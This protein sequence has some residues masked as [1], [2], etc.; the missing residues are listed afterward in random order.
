MGKALLDVANRVQ[1]DAFDALLRQLLSKR[2]S[3]HDV[4]HDTQGLVEVEQRLRHA[5]G[6]ADDVTVESIHRSLAIDRE[7]YQAFAAAL[8]TGSGKDFERSETL[9]NILREPDA[10]LLDLRLFYLTKE[11]APRKS[12]ANKPVSERHPWLADFAAGEQQRLRHALGQL[13]D[14]ER[15]SATLSVLRIG[16]S[17]V[18][19]FERA[20]RQ[21]GAYDFDDLIIRT[22]ELLGERP[23]AAWVLYKLDGGIEHLLVDEAQ[24]TSPAQWEIVRALTDEFF[25]GEG[26]H[27]ARRRTVF[28]VGDRKQSIYSFQGADP[29]VFELVH[30][31]FQTRA[32]DARQEFRDVDLSVSFRSAPEILDAVD[33]VFHPG[34]T[35]R[36]GLDGGPP[37]DW[38]HKSNRRKAE[39]LVEIWPLVEPIDR[40]DAAPWQAPVDREPAHSPRRRLARQLA[41]TIKGWI[42]KRMIPA[43]QRTVQPQD[44]LIL[45]RVRNSFFDAL[46]RAL[47]N[48]RVPVAGADRLKLGENIAILDLLALAQFCIMQED[49][50]ALACI[51]KSPVLAEPLSEDDLIAVAAVRG[52]QSL[53][54][55]LRHS[56]IP[57]CKSAAMALAVL[58]SEAAG[59]RPFEFLGK[60]LTTARARFLARLGSEA[61]DAI[62]AFLDLA[63]TYEEAHGS[64][65]AGFVN[66]FSAGDIEIKRNMEQGAGE[67]RIMTVHGAKGL[68]SPI[69]ILPDTVSAAGQ[70]KQ[71]PLLMLEAGNAK[72]PLWLAP[73]L[74]ESEIM[75]SL[76]SARQ[77]AQTDED[78]RLLYVAMTRARDQLYVCGYESA[79]TPPAD[80]WYE[81]LKNGLTPHMVEFGGKSWRLGVAPVD[82]AEAVSVPARATAPLPA[83]VAQA[84]APP[85][86]K[87]AAASPA[88]PP[89]A[90]QRVARGIL[91]HRILQQLPD[92]V[93]AGRDAHIRQVVARSGH[94]EGLA[95]A[96]VSLIRN[97]E[98]AGLFSAGGLS[99]VPLMTTVPGQAPERRRIDR[100]VMMDTHILVVDYKT[101]RHWPRTAADINPEYIQQLAAYRS[102][103]R[104]IHP[105]APLRLALLW[106]EA[107]ALMEI[108]DSILDR[109]VDQLSV[110][111][112]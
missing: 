50:H 69:V 90:V 71:D 95:D 23:D 70:H 99:E 52:S 78:R 61:N 29:S 55:S 17:I 100:L 20:K 12:V 14:L 110:T 24:D 74:F 80:C 84:L 98:F 45:V 83:W 111:S 38:H 5:L 28:V 96:L 85:P 79:R 41:R 67:V 31:E 22:S 103:L 68:K 48:E 37:R 97:P 77:N 82:L 33:K 62:D 42:G 88:Q 16:S 19:A 49:D 21:Q 86:E 60:V 64:S 6:L 18:R 65:L 91:I 4:L 35:A 75:I 58:I 30:D 57:R 15:I 112:T 106:T 92:L 109:A 66:W 59:A 25:S 56:E 36:A 89:R 101:D 107:P 47:W 26:R 32:G 76:K 104:K 39:G 81:T 54:S 72:L 11:D 43:L 10:S 51:L 44:I 94:D 2:A 27:G 46:I 40:Q 1:P 102:A 105:G 7:R 108:P 93:E 34:S 9:R 3:L 63:L 73:K 13:A 87:P 53:W 8:D